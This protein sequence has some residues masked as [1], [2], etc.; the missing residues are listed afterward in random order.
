VQV[1]GPDLPAAASS[2]G[3][4]GASGGDRTASR[5][6]VPSGAQPRSAVR[7][8]AAASSAL[9]VGV[10]PVFLAG[11]LSDSMAAE[12]GFGSAGA[13][14]AVALFFVSSAVT[15]VPMGRLT[16]RL[17]PAAALRSGVVLSA[18]VTLAIGAVAGAWW[19]LAVLL[20]LA[21]P[22]V[23]LV[24]TGGARLFTDAIRADRHGLAFGAKE[25]SIPTASML[26]GISIV[27][28]AERFGWTWAF[29]I[30][31][32]LAPG[33]LALIPSSGPAY[34]PGGRATAPGS[35]SGTSVWFAVGVAAAA[36]ASMAAATLFVPA[37]I[38]AGW[39]GAAAG[40]LLAL[41]SIVTIATRLGL[42]W[43]SDRAPSSTWWHLVGA[44]SVG[45][46]GA[47]LLASGASGRLVPVGALLLVGAG[48]GW[49]GL[50]FLSAVRATPEGPATAAGLVLTGLAAGGAVGPA[51]FGLIASRASYGTA[52][53]SC[54]LALVVAAV[55]TGLAGRARL[56][57]GAQ[58]EPES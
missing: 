54:A 5:V 14:L 58:L 31:A 12:L 15:A 44:I 21:G 50:A 11:A 25:A 48:W 6:V 46:V 57:T 27:L 32:G 40:A 47:G 2:A 22:S 52:W 16:E 36:A 28:L 53:A 1:S 13:G 26:A 43:L 35:R 45:A 30:G 10:L 4:P 24:D 18:S 49:T 55:L 17:G 3:V 38:D 41:A 34:R 33:V 42:G 19:H 39:T 51:S 9:T 37:M 7:A 20:V 29:L 56:T 8:V 23:G